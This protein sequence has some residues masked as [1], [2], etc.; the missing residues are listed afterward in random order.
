MISLIAVAFDPNQVAALLFGIPFVVICYGIHKV[1][2]EKPVREDSF[3][4]AK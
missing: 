3:V 1:V 4:A 2:I